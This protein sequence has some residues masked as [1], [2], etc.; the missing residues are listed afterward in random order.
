MRQ[1]PVRCAQLRVKRWPLHVVPGS[2]VAA[3]CRRRPA[4]HTAARGSSRRC[5]FLPR[6]RPSFFD[7]VVG[8]VPL[9]RPPRLAAGNLESFGYGL[10]RGDRFR[11]ARFGGDADLI[12]CSATRLLRSASECSNRVSMRGCQ[13][14][15]AR[16]LSSHSNSESR[17]VAPA[18]HQRAPGSWT[19]PKA[20]WNVSRLA[21]PI[22]PIGVLH[23]YGQRSRPS[24][25]RSYPVSRRW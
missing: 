18:R 12:C 5:A 14:C 13:S 10:S 9:Q 4:A 21:A 3:R 8:R 11:G 20:S 25:P 2:S 7:H 1:P 17:A 23:P 22:W 6:V 15:S 19:S 24:A 16:Q